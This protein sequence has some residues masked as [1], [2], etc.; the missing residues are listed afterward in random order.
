MK[1]G[2]KVYF[3]GT[4]RDIV[5]KSVLLV[6]DNATTEHWFDASHVEVMT[7][8]AE[9]PATPLAVIPPPA[10]AIDPDFEAAVVALR[11]V[12]S[13]PEE[14]AR[15]VVKAIGAAETFKAIGTFDKIVETAKTATQAAV[16]NAALNQQASPVSAAADPEDAGLPSA[17]DLDA[18]AEEQK[19]A[20]AAASFAEQGAAD[21]AIPLP[22]TPP[23]INAEA[24]ASPP[25]PIA[26]DPNESPA[27]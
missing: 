15:Q 17:A 5:G 24:P 27:A 7:N 6:H 21:G 20:A 12:A 23:A 2:D 4:V 1:I 19:A 18:V 3:F 14:V 16:Q 13:Y 22:P 10:E 9:A 26:A 25:S 11:Q 8:K